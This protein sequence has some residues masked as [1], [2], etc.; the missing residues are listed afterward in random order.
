MFRTIEPK[1][2]SYYRARIDLFIGLI[3]LKQDLP[4]SCEEQA[5][6][7]FIIDEGEN[8][9]IYGGAVLY[10]QSVNTLPTQLRTF[11]STCVVN[12]EDVWVCT[13]AL[14]FESTNISST[15]KDK[16]NFSQAFYSRLLQKLNEFGKE[17][18][19]D[20]LCLTL[21]SFERLRIKD[22]KVW[23][24]LLEVGPKKNLNSFFYGI[25]PL[26]HQ[27]RKLA[28][29]GLLPFLKMA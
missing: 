29:N 10:K 14:C 21:N 2:Y 17:K 16:L 3:K 9:I 26:S 20:F 25:L 8:G 28:R 27:K 11:L 15:N 22:K 7:T 19:I 13:P 23:S 12:G 1:D 6:S 18:S 24:C 4:L 5:Y